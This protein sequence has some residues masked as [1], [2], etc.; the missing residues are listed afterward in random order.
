M[1]PMPP[2]QQPAAQMAQPTME[3]QHMVMMNNAMQQ[4]SLQNGEEQFVY[5]NNKASFNYSP[6]AYNLQPSFTARALAMQTYAKPIT[7]DTGATHQMT[8]QLQCTGPGHHPSSHTI[9][10][11]NGAGIANAT[12]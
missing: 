10:V 4:H 11:A 7:C 8:C 3:Q 6:L 5:G 12:E 1:M 9:K 2:M